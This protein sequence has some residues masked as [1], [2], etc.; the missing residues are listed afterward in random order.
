MCFVDGR[1]DRRCIVRKLDRIGDDG[2][3]RSTFVHAL[4]TTE[5]AEPRERVHQ[6]CS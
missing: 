1:R 6:T 5:S 3:I 2:V 4:S